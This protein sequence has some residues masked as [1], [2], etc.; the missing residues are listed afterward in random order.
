MGR[1]LPLRIAAIVRGLDKSNWTRRYVRTLVTPEGERYK[2]TD[3]GVNVISQTVGGT[4][5]I[6]SNELPDLIEVPIGIRVK[7]VTAHPC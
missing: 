5:T 1:S 3:G 7:G 6:P 2:A 4:D